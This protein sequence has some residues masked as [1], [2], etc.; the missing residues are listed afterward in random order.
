MKTTTKNSFNFPENSIC[1]FLILHTWTQFNTHTSGR[2][3]LT[4]E[5]RN[6]ND[7]QKHCNVPQNSPASLPQQPA[8]GGGGAGGGAACRWRCRCRWRN[9][10]N[11]HSS[12]LQVETVAALESLSDWLLKLHKSDRRAFGKIYFLFISSYKEILSMFSI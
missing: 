2:F 9:L 4:G 10:L 8:G 12:S 3:N 1:R 7:H 6:C 11:S 5:F